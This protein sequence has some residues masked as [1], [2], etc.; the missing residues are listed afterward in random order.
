MP[1][2]KRMMNTKRWKQPK[3][4]DKRCDYRLGLNL[5]SSRTAEF[6]SVFQP[7]TTY[8]EE[9]LGWMMVWKGL[10]FEN[11]IRNAYS[12]ALWIEQSS[13]FEVCSQRDKK[14]H[15]QYG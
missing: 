7:K 12:R 15:K 10:P 2:S 8:T 3:I 13:R 11:K 6:K 9:L 4:I 5:S 1:A 14:Y